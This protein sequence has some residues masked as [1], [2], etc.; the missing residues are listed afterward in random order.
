MTAELLQFPKRITWRVESMHASLAD[1]RVTVRERRHG[2]ITEWSICIV[3]ETGA[4]IRAYHDGELVSPGEAPAWV[5]AGVVTRTANGLA[6]WKHLR[7]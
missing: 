5:L 3:S 6:A 2:A 1:K 7:S 4:I